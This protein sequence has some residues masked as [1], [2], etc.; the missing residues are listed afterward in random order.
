MAKTA[1]CIKQV[2]CDPRAVPS[3]TPS[4]AACQKG[5]GPPEGRRCL[6]GGTAEPGNHAD[7]YVSEDAAQRVVSGAVN[8]PPAG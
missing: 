5:I 4:S 7:E 3:V 1:H 6:L 8:I 2:N